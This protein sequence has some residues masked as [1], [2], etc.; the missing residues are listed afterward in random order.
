MSPHGSY[1]EY[2][3]TT[4]MSEL[5]I[6]DRERLQHHLDFVA[7]NPRVAAECEEFVGTRVVLK[8][9]RKTYG[10]TVVPAGSQFNVHSH[11]AGRLYAHKY[12]SVIGP[13]GNTAHPVTYALE[14]KWVRRVAPLNVGGATDDD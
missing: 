10:N 4:P 11:F 13:N 6:R 1:V 7:D 12:G 8:K 5:S 3:L 2:L 9:D 14:V